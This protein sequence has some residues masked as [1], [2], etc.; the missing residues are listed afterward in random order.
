M[1]D[2]YS[3]YPPKENKKYTCLDSG[4][5][6]DKKRELSCYMSSRK[7]FGRS[8]CKAGSI[9][10]KVCNVEAGT[11]ETCDQ[12]TYLQGVKV[13]IKQP[14]GPIFETCDNSNP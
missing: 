5:V 3:N 6:V 13:S 9:I 12:G 2:K 14:I 4:L 8:L 10:T 1:D 11:L 7:Y